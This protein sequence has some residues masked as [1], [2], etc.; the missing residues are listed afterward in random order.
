MDCQNIDIS[1]RT[2][3]INK[4]VIVDVAPDNVSDSVKSNISRFC[5]GSIVVHVYR[6]VMHHIEVEV[7]IDILPVDSDRTHYR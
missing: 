6:P 5:I 7:T 4:P 3:D 2:K 1:G